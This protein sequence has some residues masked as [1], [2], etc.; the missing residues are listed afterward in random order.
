MLEM[1]SQHLADVLGMRQV[2]RRVDLVQDVERRRLEQQQRQNQRQRHQRA[3][4]AAQFL[5]RFLPH[6]T[7]SYLDLQAI[8]DAAAVRCN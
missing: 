7:E 1:S 8:Q 6:V 3:L 2:E 5:Q 4:T